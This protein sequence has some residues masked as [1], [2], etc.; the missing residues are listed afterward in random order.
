MKEKR[1]HIDCLELLAAT[2]AMKTFLKNQ[3]NKHILLLVDNQTTVA[4]INNLGGTVSAQ[5]T[6]LAREVWMW[7]LEHQIHLMA[8]HLPGKDNVRADKELRHMKD[9]SDWM[10]NATIS[11]RAKEIFQEP[12]GQ[13]FCNPTDLPT[14]ALLQLETRSTSRSD[15][16]LPPGLDPSQGLCQPPWNLVVRVLSKV[17][18]RAADLILVAPIWP[19]QPWYPKLLGLLVANSMIINPQ[20]EVMA[21][22][23]AQL[24]ELTPPMAV[25]PI[26]GNTTRVKNFQVRLQTSCCYHGERSG[27]NPVTHCVRNGSA[28]VLNG[29]QIQFQDL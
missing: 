14:T 16:C 21:E 27:H 3:V 25:W 17:E 28:G 8:Q 1:L 5:A 19:S 15:G 13:S 11:Q 22:I 4:Y 20:E 12:G 29:K 18:E 2:L 24:Q 10:L 9:R 6:K 26:S 23:A 7:C